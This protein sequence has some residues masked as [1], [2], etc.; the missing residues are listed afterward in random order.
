MIGD[1]IVDL[2][3]AEDVGIDFIGDIQC[4]GFEKKLSGIKMADNIADLKKFLF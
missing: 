1:S 3:G 4:C 2:K